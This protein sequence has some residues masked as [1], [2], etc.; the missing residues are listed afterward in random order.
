M[1]FMSVTVSAF[2][3]VAMQA[4][5]TSNGTSRLEIRRAIYT[6]QIYFPASLQQTSLL[7]ELSSKKNENHPWT[8]LVITKKGTICRISSSSSRSSS[9]SSSNN[10]RCRRCSCRSSSSTS[11]SGRSWRRSSM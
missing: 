3:K 1:I 11:N 2:L 10:S 5:F 8:I 9:S 7:E 6:S 4:S